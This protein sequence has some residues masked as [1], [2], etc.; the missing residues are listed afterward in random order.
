[1]FGPKLS[2]NKQS[3]FS[4][5]GFLGRRRVNLSLALGSSRGGSRVQEVLVPS[6]KELERW[7][8][9]TAVIQGTED[10]QISVHLAW[11]LSSVS[12]R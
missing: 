2:G 1:M 10:K 5:T 8:T 3:T 6:S 11:L 4:V 12:S 7:R 9:R